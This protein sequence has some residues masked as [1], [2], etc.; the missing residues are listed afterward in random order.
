MG[1][2]AAMCMA[3]LAALLV[4]T[5]GAAAGSE[6]TTLGVLILHSN[7]RPTAAG[8]VIEDTLRSVV[9]ESTKHEVG[10]F[11]EYLDEEW[12][13]IS[14]YG[15]EQ[16]HFLR[17]KYSARNIRVIVAAAPLALRFAVEFRD[18]MFPGVPVVHIAIPVEML[19]RMA[20]PTDVV[21][22]PVDLDPT[23]T[24]EL[25]LRLH[26][27]AR[28]IVMVLGAGER[29]RAWEK[30]LR[31]AVPR[32]GRGV[33]VEYLAGLPTPEV[34]RRV[35]ALP[36]GTIVFTPGFFIGRGGHIGTPRQS[37]ELIAPASA[38]PVYSPVGTHLGSG[39]VGG[40][41]TPYE[42]QAKLAGALVARLLDGVAAADIATATVPRKTMVDSRQ[43]RRW[44]I[45]ESLLPADTITMFREPTLWDT[46]WRETSIGIAVVLLQA[47]LI[48]A[49]V[50]ERRSRHRTAVALA[51]SQRQM[52]HVM[53]VSMAGQLSAAIAHQLNQPLTAILGNA[54]VAQ[55]MLLR[56]NPD[57]RA[58]EEICG[59][60]VTEDQRAAE[61]IRRLNALYKKSEMKKERLDLNEL[62][63]G[64]L[65]LVHSE[66]LMRHVDVATDLARGLPPI[67]GDPVQ[68]Q[69]V[70]LN[71]VMNAVDAMEAV[72]PEERRL[73]VRTAASGAQVRLSVVDN[74]TGF[75]PGSLETMFDAFTTTKKHGM[76][77]GLAICQSIVALHEGTITA[78]NNPERGAALH[79]CLPIARATSLS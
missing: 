64:T 75:V 55:R 11:S 49:L 54:E 78:A 43:V 72:T 6:P 77:M 56:G 13:A 10:V 12:N 35:A 16:A 32:L 17:Q 23:T 25:A 29:D 51:E 57:L 40:H 47:L 62:V 52:H 19:A 44:S 53:R 68:L 71:L 3:L 59:D 39:I 5:A 8:I 38:V 76:G 27:D 24:L 37:L 28:R 7:Q 33:D 63:S 18:R 65:E 34:L 2:W 46:Y 66:L 70:V 67:D 36:A 4:G 30:R 61:V 21:G 69:Q 20:L 26:P 45:H 73:T 15:L 22:H 74:G 42:E 50:I 31:A 60:I 48:T 79:V 9:P 41:M 58:L 14:A 1:W